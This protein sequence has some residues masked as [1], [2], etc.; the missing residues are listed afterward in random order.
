PADLRSER[1]VEAALPA[2]RLLYREPDQI[3]IVV[4]V[5]G[6]EVAQLGDGREPAVGAD[7]HVGAH[8]ERLVAVKSPPDADRAAGF[9]NE[10]R[11]LRGHPALKRRELL[12]L[13]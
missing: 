4:L 5:F 6:L 11:H 8:F 12:R 2:G 1:D 10:G 7:D 13:P 3:E 9:L